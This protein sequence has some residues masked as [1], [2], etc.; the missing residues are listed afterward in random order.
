MKL[1]IRLKSFEGHHGRPGMVGG[2]LPKGAS[3][4]RL[5]APEGGVPKTSRARANVEGFDLWSMPY[6]DRPSWG[7]HGGDVIVNAKG[8]KI[9]NFI[10]ENADYFRQLSEETDRYRPP[11]GKQHGEPIGK[12]AINSI[13]DACE[14]MNR[15]EDSNKIV[16]MASH[17]AI[18]LFDNAAK[19]WN[20][21]IDQRRSGG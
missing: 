12:F 18:G 15:S 7:V 11:P 8:R 21:Y 4:S 14:Q 19:L 20:A 2:S 9:L 5:P 6:E 17:E 16:S 3:Q 10:R 13:V 1:T